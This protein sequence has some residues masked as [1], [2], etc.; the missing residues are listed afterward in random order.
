MTTRG[1]VIDEQTRP[2]LDEVPALVDE[3]VASA[4]AAERHDRGLIRER[5]RIELQRLFRRRAGRRP[6]VL[7]VVMER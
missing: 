2:I 7:P 5:V 6:V 1:F 3:V 4:S